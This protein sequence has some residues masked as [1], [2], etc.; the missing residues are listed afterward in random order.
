MRQQ[1][2]DITNEHWPLNLLQSQTLII[3][4]YRFEQQIVTSITLSVNHF[5]VPSSSFKYNNNDSWI[6]VTRKCLTIAWLWK[7][8]SFEFSLGQFGRPITLHVSFLDIINMA[9]L[10]TVSRIRPY[11]RAYGQMK[12]LA[13]V[14]GSVYGG[15]S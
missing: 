3:C 2:F 13:Q 1:F 4:N 7:E 11:Q 10:N 14:T 12:K 9:A 15:G 8:N 6:P 5:P